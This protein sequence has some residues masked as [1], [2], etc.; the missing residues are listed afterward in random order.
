MSACARASEHSDYQLQVHP[1]IGYACAGGIR[2][3]GLTGAMAI[4]EWLRDG[5]RD[6]GLDLR[7]SPRGLPRLRMPN[8]GEARLR[9]FAQAELIAADPAYGELVCFCERVTQRR[10][11]RR[12]SERAGADGP[13][14]AAPAHAG[15]DGP[16]PGLLLRS[17]CGARARPP[18]RRR[19]R[20][21]AR[22]PAMSDRARRR[23]DHR[24]G[25]VGARRRLRARPP[26]R[27]LGRGDR[28][29]GARR[30]ASRGTASTRDSACVTCAA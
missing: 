12:G 21:T 1:E 4:A 29:R 10:D 5:L 9:P 7:E 17:A 19:R 25:P 18:Q 15:A 8:I 27:R 23:G 28:P 6:G 22:A 13:R 26:R 11:P 14:W 2:S 24:S 3:T 30:A 20:G 16:L